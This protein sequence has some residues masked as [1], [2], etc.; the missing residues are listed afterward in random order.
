MCLGPHV[1]YKEVMEEEDIACVHV[2]MGIRRGEEEEEEEED[3]VH[4][5]RYTYEYIY[6]YDEEAFGLFSA[7]KLLLNPR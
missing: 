7:I 1:G 2:H 3:T 4:I 5:D 6:V